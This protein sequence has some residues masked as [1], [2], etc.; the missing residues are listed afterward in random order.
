[1]SD[2]YQ[3][4]FLREMESGSLRIGV[5][6]EPVTAFVMP[7]AY[8]FAPPW[9]GEIPENMIITEQAKEDAERR[10]K[11]ERPM[12][13]WHNATL[14]MCPRQVDL[15]INNE[16]FTLRPACCSLHDPLPETDAD[17]AAN[18]QWA[19]H[20]ASLETTKPPTIC[21]DDTH[22][23]L[24]PHVKESLVEMLTYWRDRKWID[25]RGDERGE[26][27]DR[28]SN[29]FMRNSQIARRAEK[30]YVCTSLDRLQAVLSDWRYLSDHGQELLEIPTEIM[31]SF[32][33]MYEVREYVEDSSQ[34]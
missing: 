11:L 21:S 10:A 7:V 4:Q 13:K 32:N 18:A 3:Q 24:E 14:D 12:L 9:V 29:Y 6:T 2:G 1:M 23:V 19:Q 25:V 28:E 31:R 22:R 30:A 34:A 8:T 20:L 15:D 26:H 17:L 16:D 5:C 27:I 33:T